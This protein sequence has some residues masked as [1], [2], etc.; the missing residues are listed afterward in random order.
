MSR[1][2]DSIFTAG[3][4]GELTF[5][6]QDARGL[7]GSMI[8]E[9]DTVNQ[10][11]RTME[12]LQAILQKTGQD[13]SHLV[14][15]TVFL[16]DYAD[17]GE[18]SQVLESYFSD[19]GTP[20]PA[21][22]FV[23][24]VELDGGCKVRIDSV[25]S[26]NSDKMMI[27][28]GGIPYGPG[29]RCH[30]LRAGDMIFLSGIDGLKDANAIIDERGDMFLQAGSVIDRIGIIMRTIGLSLSD[31]IRTVVFMPDLTA[32]RAFG[33]VRTEKYS[34]VFKPEEFP[35]NSG[36]GIKSLGPGVFFQCSVMA[37]Q[38]KVKSYIVSD[39]VRRSPGASCQAIRV[40]KWLFLA[41]RDPLSP[42]GQTLAVGNLGQQT[43]IVL[44]HIKE[45]LEAAGGTLDNLVKTT[46]YILAGQDVSE[47]S[48]AYERFLNAHRRT[49]SMPVSLTVGIHELIARSCLVQIDSIAYLDN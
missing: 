19:A 26:S 29:S 30:G 6:T 43:E 31:V 22:C 33:A 41:G 10:T 1:Y 18:V 46:S 11:S 38:G 36:L 8:Q 20:Y 42:D 24:I 45:I 32:R 27:Q 9:L 4:A 25:A 13:L 35:A 28:A 7:Q 23:G 39:K 16:T 49:Q 17:V 15:L 14:C 47:F 34:A 5:I 40:G 48:A 3:R 12:N 44:Q 21:T 2:S 37:T